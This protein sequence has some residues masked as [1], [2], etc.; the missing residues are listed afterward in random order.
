MRK[1]IQ[2]QSGFT[3]IE[4][5]IVVAIVGILAAIAYPSYQRHVQHGYRS[6]GI[7]ML[8]DTAA[9]LERFYAQNNTY[10]AT[11]MTSLGYTADPAL[12]SSGKY[13]V[14]LSN[15]SSTTYTVTATAQTPQDTDVC[16]NLSLTQAGVQ[17]SST[18]AANCFQ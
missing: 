9:R 17:T 14:A 10:A 8:T 1:S 16:G 3:L 12:S 15:L 13:S 18:G 6:E 7:A 5:M 11:N 4:L 2:R